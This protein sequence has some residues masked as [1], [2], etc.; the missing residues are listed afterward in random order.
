MN[1]QLHNVISDITGETGMMIIRAIVNGERDPK[2]LATYRNYR[3]KSPLAIIEKSLTGNYRDEHI[4]ALSQ[5]LE[6]FDMYQ[7]K[8]SG[9]TVL[10]FNFYY[11]DGNGDDFDNE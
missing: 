6:L 1:L 10:E 5:A 11:N 3:C 8:R 2:L 4:F 7:T 9:G